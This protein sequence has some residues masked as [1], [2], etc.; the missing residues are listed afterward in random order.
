MKTHIQ[1]SIR[2]GLILVFVV[3][4][5]VAGLSQGGVIASVFVSAAFLLTAARTIT[6]FIGRKNTQASSIGFII[7]VILY[8]IILFAMGGSEFNPYDGE[9]PTTDLAGRLF[10]VSAKYEYIDLSTGKVV[11]DYDPNQ[12]AGFGAGG[13]G[14]R[15]IAQQEK[16]DRTKFMSVAHV[17]FAIIFG[18]LGSKYATF[19]YQ[20]KLSSDLQD[21]Q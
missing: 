5:G 1:F 21:G 6:A 12:A 9:L 13:G 18:Y 8:S 14:L 3:G 15:P 7:P 16:P 19:V 11:P 4:L 17:A 20:R 10:K 2:E